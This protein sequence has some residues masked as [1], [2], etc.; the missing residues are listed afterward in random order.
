MCQSTDI[1]NASPRIARYI[2]LLRNDEIK[3]FKYF[4]D[5]TISNTKRNHNLVAVL[6][7]KINS[8]SESYRFTGA[9]DGALP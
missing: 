2:T 1:P 7:E 5:A 3:T 4:S 9:L 8:L 6:V